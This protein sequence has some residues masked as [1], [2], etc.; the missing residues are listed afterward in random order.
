MVSTIYHHI[1]MNE[2][3]VPMIAGTTMKL[4]VLITSQQ[5]YGWSPEELHFQYP[6][7]TMS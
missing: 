5:A 3:Q 7:L 1:Q 2:Q 6:H 4:V